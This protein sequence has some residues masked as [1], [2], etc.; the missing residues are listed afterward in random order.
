MYDDQYA[1]HIVAS[2]RAALLLDQPANTR[3]D[4]SA[5]GRAL[6][7]A[8]CISMLATMGVCLVH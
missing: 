7:L 6:A 4:A 5:W 8:G 1:Y 2:S 3:A